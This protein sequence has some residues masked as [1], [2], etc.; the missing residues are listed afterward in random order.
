MQIQ[1]SFEALKH[2][3]NLA[4]EHNDCTV[5]A[6]AAL[7]GDDYDTAH[8]IVADL[9]HR[10]YRGG[11]NWPHYLEA[12]K[13]MGHGLERWEQ[14]SAKTITT[15]PRELHYDNWL[16]ACSGGRHVIALC[17]GKVIDWTEGRK[18]HIWKV[19]RFT[20]AADNNGARSI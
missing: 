14:Y 17:G 7:T 13:Q 6:W 11:P 9:A 18:H 15:L 2:A 16:V 4:A 12:F 8:Y 19:W 5:M 1:Q 10:R 20:N 3:S